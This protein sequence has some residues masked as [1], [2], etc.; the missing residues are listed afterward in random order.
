M[1]V[2]IFLQICANYFLQ[3]VTTSAGSPEEIL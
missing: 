3:Q 1:L 2:T